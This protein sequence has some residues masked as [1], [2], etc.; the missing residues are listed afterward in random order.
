MHNLLN[1]QRNVR[2]IDDA[3]LKKREE[4]II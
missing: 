2:Q 4:R 3:Y 1:A